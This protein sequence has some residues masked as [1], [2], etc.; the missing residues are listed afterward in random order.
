MMER[1][2]G[3]KDRKLRA[4]LKKQDELKKEIKQRIVELDEEDDAGYLQ[5]DPEEDGDRM[6]TL[7]MKQGE[8]SQLLGVQNARS[9]FELRLD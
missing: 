9:S 3:S 8:I 1:K 5:I 2:K 4:E 6:R 7:K